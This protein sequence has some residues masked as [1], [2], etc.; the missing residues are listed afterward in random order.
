MCR[1]EKE[2]KTSEKKKISRGK[3][4]KL[5]GKTRWQ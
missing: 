4:S 3:E 2:E 1:E 5:F